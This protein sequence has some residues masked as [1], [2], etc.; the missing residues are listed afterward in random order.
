MTPPPRRTT[1]AAAD[2]RDD[3]TAVLD[4]LRRIV[5]A[6]RTSSRTVEERLGVS[7]AQLLVL[8]R[9]AEGPANSLNDLAERTFTH[10]SSM[11]IVVDR[12]VAK[13]LVARERSREDARRIV[14]SLTPAGRAL[15]R[16]APR[17]AHV[18]LNEAIGKLPAARVRELAVDLRTVVRLMGASEQRAPLFL[19]ED[20]RG[21]RTLSARAATRPAKRR[22]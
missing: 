9:L 6:L 10:Q 5:R 19:E 20:V 18:R 1:A 13:G 21:R 14:L 11:S 22:R 8:Q 15:V 7:G 2:R 3:R 16:G 17:V 12:L 4:A